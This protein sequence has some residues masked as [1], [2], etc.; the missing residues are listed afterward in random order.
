[1]TD[2]EA[3]AAFEILTAAGFVLSIS[4]KAKLARRLRHALKN[5]PEFLENVHR[6]WITLAIVQYSESSEKD[7]DV[8]TD[9]RLSSK[10]LV[11]LDRLFKISVAR[12]VYD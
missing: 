9:F 1:M 2:D 10:V 5:D 11:R 6:G 3:L 7:V 12:A 4:D 8:T